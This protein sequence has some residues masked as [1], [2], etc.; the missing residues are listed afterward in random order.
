[1]AAAVPD[2]YPFDVDPGLDVA[3]YLTPSTTSVDD[4]V[5]LGGLKGNIGNQEYPIP[6]DADLRKYDS[7]VLWCRPFTV[8]IAT[9]ELS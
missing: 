9:A 3:V 5:D 1:M 8:R 7:V 6:P 4:R 2:V